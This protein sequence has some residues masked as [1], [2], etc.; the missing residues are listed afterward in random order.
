[1]E[2]KEDNE[3]KNVLYLTLIAVFIATLA[4]VGYLQAANQVIALH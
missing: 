1:M 2:F 4:F 3:M